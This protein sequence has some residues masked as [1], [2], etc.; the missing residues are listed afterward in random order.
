MVF[1]IC[2]VESR[3]T[4]WYNV[5]SDDGAN[6]LLI[7]SEI[8]GVPGETRPIKIILNK[9][10]AWESSEEAYPE[11]ILNLQKAIDSKINP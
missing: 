2:S 10:P 9:T 6:F 5:F 3:I 1:K 8:K 4:T 11:L 7:R